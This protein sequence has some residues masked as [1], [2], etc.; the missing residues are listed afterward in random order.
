MLRR[1]PQSAQ[2][3]QNQLPAPRHTAE[4]LAKKRSDLLVD[5]L[6]NLF[7]LET[8]GLRGATLPS[9][10]CEDRIVALGPLIRSC[11][12]R[13]VGRNSLCRQETERH[14]RPY[15]GTSILGK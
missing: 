5:C 3:V 8:D 12:N 4:R 6:V 9:E 7:E 10:T 11:R 14:T 1:I 13:I 2:G 15:S